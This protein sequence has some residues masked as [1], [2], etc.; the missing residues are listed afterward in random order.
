MQPDRTAELVRLLDRR[1]LV[2]D[3]AMGTM[4]Q[5]AKLG[6][7]DFRGPATCGLHGHAHE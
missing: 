6:E 4:I 7:D 1:I 3:G 2:L 5:Q